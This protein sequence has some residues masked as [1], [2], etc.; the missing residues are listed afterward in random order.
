MV[1]RARIRALRTYCLGAQ[2]EHA[3]PFDQRRGDVGAHDGAHR[4]NILRLGL[5]LAPHDERSQQPPLRRAVAREARLT[6]R[7]PGDVVGHLA[8]QETDGVG[9]GDLDNGKLSERAHARRAGLLRVA[10]WVNASEYGMHVGLNRSDRGLRAM[11]ARGFHHSNPDRHACQCPCCWW[12][13]VK[14]CPRR[15]TWCS[16]AMHLRGFH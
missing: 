4:W 13:F 10:G 2:H 14:D 7:G 9:T 5:R 12:L 6:D 15:F 11:A 8:L 1:A 16:S 3:E